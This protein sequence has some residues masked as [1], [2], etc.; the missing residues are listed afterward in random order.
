VNFVFSLITFIVSPLLV[1][2]AERQGSPPSHPAI[3]ECVVTTPNGIAA[4]EPQSDPSSYGNREISVGPF[5]LW[6]EGTVV[7]RPSGAGFITRDGALGMKF[8]WRRGISGA[9]TI[10]GRRL[11]GTAPPL[12]AEVPHGY[13]EHG[14]QA[15]YVIFP[16]PGCWEV[17]G[18]VSEASVTFVT[19][20]V[21]IGEGPSW[22]RNLP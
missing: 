16:T 12:R 4:G 5:G 6:P 19:K 7:F 22:R 2:S 20:V 3:A 1:G 15:S 14:F 10:E 11:D 8:G 21:K 13:G 18:R 9:L 17:T